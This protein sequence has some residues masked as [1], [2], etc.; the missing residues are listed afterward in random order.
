[1]LVENAAA[2]VRRIRVVIRN[3]FAPQIKIGA[4]DFAGDDLWSAVIDRVRE[5]FALVV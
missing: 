5:R 3:P 2:I 4:L 1:M